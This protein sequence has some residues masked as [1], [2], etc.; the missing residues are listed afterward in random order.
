[1]KYPVGCKEVR[2]A[3]FWAIEQ[4][5]VVIVDVS[6]PPIGHI[7]RVQGSWNPEY[8]TEILCRN[9]GTKLPLLSA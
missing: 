4:Q 8:G 9:V 6:G 7:L 5:V 1:M 3:L 2:T